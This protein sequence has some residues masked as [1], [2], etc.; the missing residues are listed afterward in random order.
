MRNR[1]V[2]FLAGIVVLLLSGC[3]GLKIQGSPIETVD[4]VPFSPVEV[5]EDVLKRWAHA[6][7][8]SDT[9]PG[10]SIDRAYSELIR[11]AKGKKVIVAVID[12]GVDIEHEDLDDVIWVN[13]KEVPNNGKDDD[14]NG[15]I[16]DIHGWNFIGDA[17]NENLELTRML[18]EEGEGSGTYQKMQEEL[19]QK[20]AEARAQLL[21][22][23]QILQVIGS[24]NAILKEHFGTENYTIED[25]KGL[26]VGD[27]NVMRAKGLFLFLDENDLD[28]EKLMDHRDYLSR[29]LEYNLNLDFDGR[30]IVGDD[31]NDFND[32]DYG[33]NNV[34]GPDE[35]KK[36]IEHGTHV[37]GII[38]AE[39]GNSIGVDGTA[40]NVEVMV[41]RAVPDGDEYDKDVALAIR[42]AVDNGAK[43]INNSF[44]KDHSPHPE[45]VYDAITYAATKD[46]LIVNAAGNDSK[47]LDKPGNEVYPNDAREDGAEFANNFITVGAVTEL[48]GEDMVAPFSNYGESSVDVFAP[49]NEIWST[50]PNNG[51]DYRQGTSMASPFVAGVAALIRSYFPSLTAS[52]VKQVVMD[53]GIRVGRDVKV[54]EGPVIKPFAEISRTGSIVNAY[55]ALILA[56]QKAVS[57]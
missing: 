7:L 42:Y 27:A 25:V 45:W 54:G 17:I 9:L 13:K 19:Q 21:Q 40:N 57:Q 16:D 26:N 43:V 11:G 33:N 34:M 5:S 46:V 31:P 12:S 36:N 39:R 41:L 2:L 14:N 22:I 20:Q 8:I 50:L 23:E 28:E 32:R 18:R 29:S 1:G 49:G 47:D 55:N 15:Y 30:A 56:S 4:T 51:Y 44:G 37:S 35:S 52:E 48:Y 10:M 24:A 3:A 53:S 38:A 6:D